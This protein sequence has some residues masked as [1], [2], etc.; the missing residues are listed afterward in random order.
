[1]ENGSGAGHFTFELAPRYEPCEP[2]PMNAKGSKTELRDSHLGLTRPALPDPID[3]TAGLEDRP[4]A[5]R[6]RMAHADGSIS[7]A[8][9]HDLAVRE[10]IGDSNNRQHVPSRERL[11]IVR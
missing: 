5:F 2:M 8:D 6:E 7:D 11:R 10:L 9:C 4:L 3:Q 1:M